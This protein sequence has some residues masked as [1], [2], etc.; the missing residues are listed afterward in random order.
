MKFLRRPNLVGNQVIWKIYQTQFLLFG[1]HLNFAKVSKV[2]G[3]VEVFSKIWSNLS[4]SFLELIT[5]LYPYSAFEAKN[6]KHLFI[7]FESWG[8]CNECKILSTHTAQYVQSKNFSKAENFHLVSCC[9][10]GEIWSIFIVGCQN[11]SKR[12]P[13]PKSSMNNIL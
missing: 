7:E 4:S 11:R 10:D 12:L 2:E 13:Y 5:W 3:R 9:C 1:F 8:L 6:K